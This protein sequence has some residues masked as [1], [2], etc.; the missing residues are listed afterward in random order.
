MKWQPESGRLNRL[1]VNTLDR[2]LVTRVKKDP[3]C[4]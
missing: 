2:V 4:S 1:P 3:G